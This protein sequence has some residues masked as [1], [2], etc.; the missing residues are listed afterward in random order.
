[1]PRVYRGNFVSGWLIREGIYD[2]VTIE[3]WDLSSEG[4]TWK[5]FYTPNVHV[6]CVIYL[7]VFL[8]MDISTFSQ[9]N[10]PLI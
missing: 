9:H 1:M 3:I 4:V 2:E 6:L 5:H 10:L 8:P 7:Y